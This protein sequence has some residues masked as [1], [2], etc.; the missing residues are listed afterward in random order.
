LPAVKCSPEPTVAAVEL[1]L[2]F[3]VAAVCALA[4]E[5]GSNPLMNRAK[6][7]KR[8]FFIIYRLSSP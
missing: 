5:A 1:L 6:G 4:T 2:K 3:Q 7:K 8:G